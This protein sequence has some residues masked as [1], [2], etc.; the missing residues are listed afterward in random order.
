MTLNKQI[1]NN[2]LVLHLYNSMYKVISNLSFL[3]RK[4]ITKKIILCILIYQA[5]FFHERNRKN[6]YVG[7]IFVV[8]NFSFLDKK[9]KIKKT[10]H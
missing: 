7:L 9:K 8:K 6:R 3:K 1:R 5:T 2:I 4:E 10:N